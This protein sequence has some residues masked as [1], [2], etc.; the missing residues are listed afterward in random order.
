MGDVHA[1][2]DHEQIG[3]DE[4]DMIGVERLGALA[5]LLEEHRDAD[6]VGAPLFHQVAGIGERA[7]GFED[8][9]DE[10][11][12]AAAD[13][14]VD[15]AEHRDLARRHRP[16]PIARQRQELDFRRQPRRMQGADQVGGEDEAALEDRDDQQIDI[17]GVGD[18]PRQLGI[19]QRD[20]LRVVEDT[21]VATP[22]RRH[23]RVLERST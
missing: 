1:V 23:Q 21:D 6:A 16:G 4:A 9:V 13:I 20:P 18:L 12:V 8:V 19:A 3:T 15:V 22:N 17:A 2:A 14:A 7:A 5:G 11:H 10:Q